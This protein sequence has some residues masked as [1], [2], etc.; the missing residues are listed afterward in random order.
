[1]EQREP[2]ELPVE[3]IPN[4]PPL[5]PGR[6]F[7]FQVQMGGWGTPPPPPP[8]F[9]PHR[10]RRVWPLVL[11]LLTCLSTFW[12]GGSLF[13]EAPRG[14]PGGQLDALELLTSFTLGGLKYSTALM[15]I[16]VAHEM[17]HFVQARRYGIPASWPWFIPMPFSPLG[18]MGAV[19]VQASG[20]ADRKQMFDIGITGPLAGLV[21]AIPI[22][23]WGL[24]ESR[25]VQIDAFD[26]GLTFGNPPLLRW[27]AERQFGP[28]RPDQDVV[29]TPLLH[30]GWVGILIT[31]LN[32]IPIG[33]LDGG[34]I[35]YGL[36]GR[37]AHLVAMLLLWAAAIWTVVSGN[38][39]YSVM[40]FLLLAMGPRHPPS[41]D[42][43]VPLGTFRTVLGWL[44]L[45]FVF[46]GFT[47]NPITVR[48]PPPAT[49]EPEPAV[50]RT[51]VQRQPPRELH[52]SQTCA[53]RIG[54]TANRGVLPF[55]KQKRPGL[56][57]AM[58][59]ALSPRVALP[60]RGVEPLS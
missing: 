59:A 43:S 6:P 53:E 30:A 29:L 47:P 28:L 40:I 22:A 16:L 51:W 31:A 21:V 42:D 10:P 33:Q 36:I 17:G 24:Q 56:T 18:T 19:I 54:D 11:F 4:A 49:P 7:V 15:A 37:R 34:H 8:P 5:E 2:I 23:I 3:R 26:G 58:Q 13:M 41:R 60:P 39:S 35:L 32:L 14:V 9:A 45:G 48:Q 50:E 52:P 38:W 46:L 25:V 12:V 55:P 1:M 44:T 20:R 27:L 57:G